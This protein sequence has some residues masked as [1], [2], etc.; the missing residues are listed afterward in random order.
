MWQ[1][2]H[3]SINTIQVCS[4]YTF[5]YRAHGIYGESMSYI[6]AALTIFVSVDRFAISYLK[7]K[8]DWG[9]KQINL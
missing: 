6:H 8:A 4:K 1:N 3:Y 5:V 9:A 2:Y 7:K